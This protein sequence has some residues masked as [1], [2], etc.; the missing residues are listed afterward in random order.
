[1]VLL[2]NLR[3]ISFTLRDQAL[4]PPFEGSKIIA[5]D[6]YFLLKEKWENSLLVNSCLTLSSFNHC[7]TQT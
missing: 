4:N 5:F 3:I 2:H 6:D 7:A 1:M